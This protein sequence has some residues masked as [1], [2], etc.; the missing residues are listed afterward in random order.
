MY[1]LPR[2]LQLSQ[3]DSEKTLQ[4]LHVAT[5][6]EFNKNGIDFSCKLKPGRAASRGS[7]RAFSKLHEPALK[8][9]QTGCDHCSLDVK[10]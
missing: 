9:S 3:Q 10:M 6:G 8:E 2:G 5:K 1:A 4:E 7:R